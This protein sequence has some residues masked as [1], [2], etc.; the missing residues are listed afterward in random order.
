VNEESHRLWQIRLGFVGTFTTLVTIGVGV[1]SYFGQLKGNI[2]LEGIKQRETA[3][4]QFR[5][6]QFEQKQVAFQTAAQLMGKLATATDD[7]QEFAKLTKEFGGHYWGAMI[8]NEDAVIEK[9]MVDYR[10]V[11]GTTQT[12]N[13]NLTIRLKAQ[14]AITI[15]ALQKALTTELDSVSR[16][17]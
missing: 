2:E 14:T 3:T 13:L 17:E 8:L 15:K 12:H 16:K 1:F 11:L 7:D 5:Q 9:A 10:D 4:Y 6:K